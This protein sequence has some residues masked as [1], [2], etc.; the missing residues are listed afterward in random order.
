MRVAE[1]QQL[2][3]AAP[4]R[5]QRRA[6]PRQ[7]AHGRLGLG[8]RGGGA[9]HGLGREGGVQAQGQG[10]AVPLPARQQCRQVH[11]ELGPVAA[12]GE[13]ELPR[14]SGEMITGWCDG[15]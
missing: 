8:L 5:V 4:G 2:L 11:E 6:Q 9:G 10:P 13:V 7:L 15:W 14:F 12:P 1:D 3:R